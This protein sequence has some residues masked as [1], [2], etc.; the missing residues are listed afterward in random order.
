MSEVDKKLIS[1]RD[2]RRQRAT[3]RPPS[4]PIP[5]SY[6]QNQRPGEMD[7]VLLYWKRWIRNPLATAGNQFFT[8]RMLWGNGLIAGL[9]RAV[10]LLAQ[11]QFNLMLLISAIVNTLFI[12]FLVYYL[13]TFIAGWLLGKMGVR[14]VSQEGLRNEIIALSGWIFLVM[15]A[16]V[17]P[18]PYVLDVALL[19]FLILLTRSIK[20][21][22][23]ASWWQAI[24]SSLAGM[25]S[26]MILMTLF[27]HL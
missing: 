10:I 16:S 17:I 19:G 11:Q 24:V 8:E 3:R 23:H 9:A 25:M 1:L 5:R 15:I 7:D 27:A 6:G 22:A 2:K 26:V 4:R 14:F 12:F 21:S 20:L 18:V 13:V